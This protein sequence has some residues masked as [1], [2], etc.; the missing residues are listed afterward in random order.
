[1]KKVDLYSGF[2]DPPPTSASLAEWER[3]RD[4]MASIE[5]RTPDVQKWI[6]DADAVIHR[7]SQPAR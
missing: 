2:V 4:E 1:M 6:S 7:L 5:P 3:F